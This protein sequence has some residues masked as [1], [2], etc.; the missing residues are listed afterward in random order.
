MFL[1]AVS[2]YKSYQGLFK[3]WEFYI[4]D[5]KDLILYSYF[6]VKTPEYFKLLESVD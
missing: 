4:I 5:K 1:V 2:L 6:T 3:Q